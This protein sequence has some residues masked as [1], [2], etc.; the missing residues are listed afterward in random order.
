MRAELAAHVSGN[1]YLNFLEGDEKLD[2]TQAGFDG[3]AWPRLRAVK[4]A[5][6]PDNL[7]DHGLAL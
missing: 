3:D 4:A 7:F 1:A 5:F 6:D 2:R